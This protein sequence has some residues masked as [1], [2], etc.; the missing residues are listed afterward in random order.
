MGITLLQ[1]QPARLIRG[2]SAAESG[3]WLPQQ[4]GPP[5]EETIVAAARL[6]K[7]LFS[8]EL[9]AE[10]FPDHLPAEETAAVAPAR[11]SELAQP[12]RTF[13]QG[14]RVALHRTRRLTVLGDIPVLGLLV[15]PWLWP[16]HLVIVGATAGNIRQ[17][18]DASLSYYDGNQ[19]APVR[20]CWVVAV[21]AFAGWL[22][23]LSGAFAVG[24]AQDPSAVRIV[25]T[26]ALLPALVELLALLEF[27]VMN[28]E[29]VTIKR[30]QS[31][32]DGRTTLVLTSLVSRRDGHDFAARLIAAM[33][34]RWQADDVVI[35]GYP[36]SKA[37]IS[38]YVRLGARRERPAGPSE[39][40]ARRRV[41][42]DC[43]RP[44]RAR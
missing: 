32:S 35:I 18:P 29:W 44:L 4:A 31:R 41:S 27:A 21:L 34:P 9:P 19:P 2:S 12:V 40:P 8:D 38:Y 13:R 5:A 28:P 33:Y 26:V 24:S 37:L 10:L 1:E 6:R 36:A 25:I 42:I 30:R 17:T 39:R 20:S 16:L 11:P 7:E 43:R 22:T 3:L 14:A 15:V 23:A